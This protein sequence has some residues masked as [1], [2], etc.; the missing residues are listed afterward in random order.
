MSTGLS[1]EYKIGV[2]REIL[3]ALRKVL[4][5][6]YPEPQLAGK[7]SVVAE[8]PGTEIQYP[9]VV[10][11]FNPGQI[12][13]IGI[14]HYELSEDQNGVPIRVL[15]WTFDGTVSFTVNALTT[16]DRDMV[17]VGLIN[18]LAFGAEIPEFQSF[19]KEIQ[20][21]DFVA[22][23]LMSESLQETGDQTANPSWDSNNELIFTDTI[24]VPIFGE[25]F[26][27]PST[28]NL[29]RISAV[30]LYPYRYDQGIP[31]GSQAIDN[32]GHN[33]RTVPWSP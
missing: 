27:N 32:E 20:D 30:N 17:I 1:Y 3:S 13:N 4:G 31:T 12:K 14:G 8:Y 7:I 22:I 25:F 2:K 5:E 33:D 6:T 15:H 29:V 21:Y 16:V 19:R 24:I 28:G 11:R 18:L 26:T 23:S 9:M 10:L